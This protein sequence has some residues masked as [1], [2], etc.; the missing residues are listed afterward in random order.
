MRLKLSRFA[1]QRCGA[2]CRAPGEVRVSGSE[3]DAMA[4]HLE[5]E[6]VDFIERYVALTRDRRGLT[7][8][9]RADGGCIFLTADNRCV[10]QQVKPQQCRDYPYEWRSPALDAAC[11]GMQLL[12]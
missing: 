6:V 4:Q 3:I 11:P 1:C 12:A 9:D 5:L 2:C 7:L 8:T 10:V